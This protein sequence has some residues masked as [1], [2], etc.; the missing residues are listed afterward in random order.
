[1]ENILQ[2]EI[3]KLGIDKLIDDLE[4]NLT[5]ILIKY[6]DLKPTVERIKN[7]LDIFHKAIRDCDKDYTSTSLISNAQSSIQGL[8]DLFLPT[9]DRQEEDIRR[10]S[11][12]HINKL[13]EIIPLFRKKWDKENFSKFLE[14]FGEDL[15]SE[16]D[17]FRAFFAK[18]HNEAT[19]IINDLREKQT[20]SEKLIQFLSEATISDFYAKKASDH[21]K[22]ARNW[23]IATWIFASATILVLFIALFYQILKSI[24]VNSINYALLSSKILLTATLGLVAKWTSKQATRHNIEE[25]KYRRLSLNMATLKPFIETLEDNNKNEVMAAIAIKTFTDSGIN[26]FSADFEAPNLA[27]LIKNYL[28]SGTK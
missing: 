11:F 15:K 26:E 22:I 6:P 18:C 2:K 24:D 17:S 10:D 1:M 3:E 28:N 14:E 19:E 27:D 5:A 9:S 23:I 13:L 7:V 16:Q 12:Y 8:V 21:A 20:E 4:Q 25:L